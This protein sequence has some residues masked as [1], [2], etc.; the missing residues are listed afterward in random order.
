MMTDFTKVHDQQEC[1]EKLEKVYKFIHLMQYLSLCL[2]IP[3]SPRVIEATNNW[4]IVTLDIREESYTSI[5][6]YHNHACDYN[7]CSYTVRHLTLK[8]TNQAVPRN[9]PEGW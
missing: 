4:S 3:Q 5:S 8:L 1:I 6:I 2:Q 7:L 9:L